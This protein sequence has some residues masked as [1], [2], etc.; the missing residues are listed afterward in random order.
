MN[1]PNSEVE[2][3]IA[4]A[5]RELYHAPPPTPSEEMWTEIQS[6]LESDIPVVPINSASGRRSRGRMGWWVG[7][8]AALAIGLGLGRLSLVSTQASDGDPV[9]VAE[10]SEHP[11]AGRSSAQRSTLPYMLATRN[12]LDRAESFLT[13]VR[14]DR[15][16]GWDDPQ[17][18]PW[19]RSLLSRTRLL[20]VT[21]AAAAPEMRTLL[22]DL[23]LMLMQ[24]VVTADTGD[25]QEARI[26]DQ[27]L[28][29][30]DLLFRLRSA[31]SRNIGLVRRP[32]FPTL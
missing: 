24:I 14:S 6:R 18:G 10:V 20:M 23:E 12:H 22:E 17:I 32:S 5:A 31:T 29:E 2:A 16:N 8:A 15:S 21:P 7:I 1:E 9:A 27:G 19:A 11:A 4:S 28:E 30:S 3:R 13:A 26:V 25:P